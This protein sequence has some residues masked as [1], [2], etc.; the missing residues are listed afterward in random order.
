MKVEIVPHSALL[1]GHDL[2]TNVKYLIVCMNKKDFNSAQISILEKGIANFCMPVLLPRFD[3]KKYEDYLVELGLCQLVGGEL[4]I[5]TV[6]SPTV[7]S[8]LFEPHN[9][10]SH[11]FR[12]ISIL[13]RQWDAFEMT[14]TCFDSLL[15]SDYKSKRILMLDDASKDD[16][17]LR[18]FLTYKDVHVVRTLDKLE[19]CH[20]FN[21]LAKYAQKLGSTSIFIVNNDTCDFSPDIF[22]VLEQNLIQDVG[23]VSSRV[24]DYSGS[25]IV[26]QD[27][28]WLGIPFNIATEGY[29]IPLSVWERIGGFNPSLV[30]YTEDLELCW[31]MNKIG[32]KQKRVDTVYFSHLGNGSSSRQ[33]FVP[34]YFAA[35]NFI[36]IQKIYFPGDSIFRIVLNSAKKTFPGVLKVNSQTRKKSIMRRTIY[37]S[38]GLI[39]G[40]FRDCSN[41]RHDYDP[42]EKIVNPPLRYLQRLR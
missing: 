23:I 21:L 11:E 27:R 8:N 36:W 22:E 7:S 13:V 14:S 28:K 32:L 6:K 20:S 5:L 1:S 30:R 31:Q 19:Y 40:A 18:I 16:S 42:Y 12:R 17:Y 26:K 4:E 3:I 10:V 9:N 2:Y 41:R 38:L 39:S 34:I 29:L 33:N 35:R 15:S 25:V 24:R 37:L